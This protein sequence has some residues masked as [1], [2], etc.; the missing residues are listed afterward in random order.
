MLSQ[1]ILSDYTNTDVIISLINFFG[2]NHKDQIFDY[3]WLFANFLDNR[4][5]KE[6]ITKVP[7]ILHSV[8]E[9][10]IEKI[11][12]EERSLRISAINAFHEPFLNHSFLKDILLSLLF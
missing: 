3:S 1:K 12:K 2:K 4:N 11:F 10:L 6:I 9:N 8:I 7:A 5:S